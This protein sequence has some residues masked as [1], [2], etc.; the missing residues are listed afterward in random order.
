MNAEISRTQRQVLELFESQ[1]AYLAGKPR[2]FLEDLL[3]ESEDLMHSTSF[4]TR[5]AADINRTAATLV[6]EEKS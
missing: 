1:R 5:T 2:Q 4:L 6:L 3:H